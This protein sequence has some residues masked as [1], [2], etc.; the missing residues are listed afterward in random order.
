MIESIVSKRH[1]SFYIAAVVGLAA[2]GLSL[3]FLPRVAYVIAVDAFFVIYVM[4]TARKMLRSTPEL[5][6]RNIATADEPVWIIFAITFGAVVVAVGSLFV[7]I[8]SAHRF[9]PLDLSLTLAA[10]PLGWLSIHMMAAVHYAHLYW[11]PVGGRGADGKAGGN[12]G[13][14]AFQS[15]IEPGG[16]EFL[17]FAYVIGMAT[18]TSDTAITSTEMRKINLLHGMVSFFFNTVLVAAAVNVAV[19]LGQ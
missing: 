16:I 18:E 6:Q 11:R 14:L 4:L 12:A 1:N 2:L 9:Y 7:L 15:G 19:S 10:V 17:Y 3:A 5:L 13:G 8:N